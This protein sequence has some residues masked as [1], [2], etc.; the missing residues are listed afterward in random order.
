MDAE[1]AA[2]L[3]GDAAEFLGVGQFSGGAERHR[4]REDSRSEE[5]RG[6]NA[7]LEVSGDQQRELRVGCSWFIRVTVWYRSLPFRKWPAAGM[8]I[9]SEPTWYLRMLSRKRRYSGLLL[10][11]NST[12]MRTM[13]NCP[14][15]LLERERAQRAF[16]PMFGDDDG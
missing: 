1:G 3:R 2:F 11:R 13:N 14:T 15:F 8:D 5:L 12:R 7:P 16:C 4:V 6:K 9:A 10:P